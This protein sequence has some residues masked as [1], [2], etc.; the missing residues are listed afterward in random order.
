MEHY[1]KIVSRNLFKKFD[2]ETATGIVQGYDEGDEL[3]INV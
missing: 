2:F 1:A 3:C